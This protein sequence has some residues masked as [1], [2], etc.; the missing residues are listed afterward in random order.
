MP[1]CGGAGTRTPIGFRPAVFKTAALPV[2]STPPSFPGGRVF[3]R[4]AR[5]K[6]RANWAWSQRGRNSRCFR[7]ACGGGQHDMSVAGA[8]GRWWP[9]RN[10]VPRSGTGWMVGSRCNLLPHHPRRP[11]SGTC[12]WWATQGRGIRAGLKPAPTHGAPRVLKRRAQ[13]PMLHE[14]ARQP[15]CS[16]APC[17]RGG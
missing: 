4:A 2:R 13:G 11:A 16:I 1:S 7:P 6:D 10:P 9:T 12:S 8:E 5:G 15:F 14:M 3:L 17:G